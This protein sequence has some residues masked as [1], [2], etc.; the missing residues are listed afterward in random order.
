MRV[1]PPVVGATPD[2][3]PRFRSRDDEISETDP[4]RSLLTAVEEFRS[5][6]VSS[7]AETTAENLWRIGD[8]YRRLGRNQTALRYLTKSL[9]LAVSLFREQPYMSSLL[10]S[11]GHARARLGQH[12]EAMSHYEAAL[13]AARRSDRQCDMG[14]ALDGIGAL[15]LRAAEYR[16][17]LAAFEESLNIWEAIGDPAGLAV[18]ADGVAQIYALLG[19]DERAE[20]W[21]RESLR[22]AREA[23]SRGTEAA[24]LGTTGAYHHERGRHDVALEHLY[25]AVTISHELGM[26]E[27]EATYHF[28]IVRACARLG[29]FQSAF[30]HLRKGVDLTAGTGDTIC[31]A[32]QLAAE[33]S[34]HIGMGAIE[35]GLRLDLDAA[36]TAR[37]V[38][39]VRMEH[40]LSLEISG[41]YERLGDPGGALG[42]FKRSHELTLTLL[43]PELRRG[44]SRI[45]SRFEAIRMTDEKGEYRVK[46]AELEQ[47]VEAKGNELTSVALHLAQRETLL[48]GIRKYIVP[49]LKSDQ[50]EVAELAAAVLRQMGHDHHEDAAWKL[51]DRQFRE[52]HHDFVRALSL[53]CP[54]LTPMELKICA[55]LRM[56]MSS[57]DIAGTLTTS[58]FTVNTHRRNIRNKLELPDHA[59]LST[60][61]AAI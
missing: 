11:L 50:R 1:P 14:A 20:V 4:S 16:E 43:S 60:Y 37:T 47:E 31:R 26:R 39:F 48:E 51:F 59:N 10:R 36:D 24:V 33:A 57:K 8:A 7:D 25:R 38:G 54:S 15:R 42:Y 45:E 9:D 53:R 34:I 58:V 3:H 27:S 46:V 41:L 12:R 18:V 29:E 52:L 13:E 44:L 21:F 5:S 17:A 40:D 55:L 32:A 49:F 23:G 6:R 61:L 19:D 2:H 30:E 22:R 35:R 56:S 28:A